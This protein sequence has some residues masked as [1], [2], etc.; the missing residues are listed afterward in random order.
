MNVRSDWTKVRDIGELWIDITKAKGHFH[1]CNSDKKAYGDALGIGKI[2]R[3]DLDASSNVINAMTYLTKESQHLRIK[4][5]GGRTLRM[6]RSSLPTRRVAYEA[7][8][9]RLRKLV[10]VAE[11]AQ[12]RDAFSSVRVEPRMA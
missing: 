6:V 10:F 1:N 8:P 11:P 5:E 2:H 12:R 4:P 3:D 7:S 9:M